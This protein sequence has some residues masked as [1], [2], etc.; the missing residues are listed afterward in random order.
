MDLSDK[1][2]F[3]WLLSLNYM[4]INLGL[5]FNNV[6]YWHDINHF[7]IANILLMRVMFSQCAVW[8]NNSC[9]ILKNLKALLTGEKIILEF[10]TGVHDWTLTWNFFSS[11]K[12]PV[13]TIRSSLSIVGIDTQQN[14]QFCVWSVLKKNILG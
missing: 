12:S 14:V 9:I 1:L 7:S 10:H 5:R 3:L 8:E 13:T 11:K 6:R 2:L 4:S